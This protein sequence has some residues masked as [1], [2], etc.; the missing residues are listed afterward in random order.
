[1]RPSHQERGTPSSGRAGR[2][3]ASRAGGLPR[4]GGRGRRVGAGL[5]HP[6]QATVP[7]V[8]YAVSF[9]RYGTLG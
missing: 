3:S 7:C 2:S 6:P 4:P 1:M 9:Y 5:L 8:L